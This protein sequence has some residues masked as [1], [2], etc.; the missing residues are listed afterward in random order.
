MIEQTGKGTN[1][2]IYDDKL[3]NELLVKRA[4][5]TEQGMGSGLPL[6]DI[7]MED[8]DGKE[9]FFMISGRLI[10]TL[11]AAV[12]GVNQRIHGSEEP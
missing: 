5:I 7:V 11:S 9:Y 3:S 12:K 4:V 8:S 2:K 6:V 10:N 1:L